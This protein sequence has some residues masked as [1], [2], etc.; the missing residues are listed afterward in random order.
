MSRVEQK[1]VSLTARAAWFMFARMLAFAFSFAQP[2][3]LVRR[4][5][6]HDFGLYK[7]LFLIVTTAITTLPFGFGMSAFYF[8]PREKDRQGAVVFNILIFY[9]VVG[10]LACLA[11]IVHPA[12]LATIFNSTDLVEYAPAIALLSLLWMI[13]SFL[14]M[15]AVANEESKLA[16]LF[17]I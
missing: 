2:L 16:T 10:G 11:L 17:I 5:S 7:Q 8:L 1:E 4:L 9:A 13:A 6:Q 14:E 15:V 3:L 12:L